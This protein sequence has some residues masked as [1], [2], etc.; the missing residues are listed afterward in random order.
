[1]KYITNANAI[2]LILSDNTK[3]RVEKTDK[4]YPKVLKTF[5]LPQ[6]EQDDAI[7]ALLNPVLLGKKAVTSAEG[8][9]VIDDQIF[10][11]GERLPA[12][13]EQKVLSIMQDGLPLDHFAKFWERLQNNPS[14]T[15]I[16]EL[17]DF[18][19]Y[20][21]LPITEDGFFIA[22]KGVDSDYWSVK[23]N[24]STK[25]TQGTV[26]GIGRILN[27]IGAIIEVP[28]RQVDDNRANECSHGLHVGSLDYVVNGYD[29]NISVP[30]Y[31]VH[32]SV[33]MGGVV[34]PY[35]TA[36]KV[37]RSPSKRIVI[38]V[39][40]GKLTI[41]I[42]RESIE[43]LPSNEKVFLEIEDILT[44]I[45]DDEIAGLTPPKFGDVISRNEKVGQN[46]DGE[47]FKY[48]FDKTFPLTYKYH[49]FANIAKDASSGYDGN[50]T[51]IPLPKGQV[52]HPIYVFPKIKSSLCSWHT[53]L[54]VA[55]KE[56]QKADR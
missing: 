55:L 33:R 56:L 18:L 4:N 35:K 45:S 28:R 13:L 54:Q 26:D 36:T 53:R 24:T 8:F 43:N 25:V 46:Y 10:Y 41:P 48:S 5:E 6:D 23:G 19:S 3:V 42:T 15:S 20:K 7:K 30:H 29:A 39:P 51:T 40:I 34:Y 32:Y 9:E 44:K 38:D 11:Q 49:R 2:I 50:Y 21:E 1:M 17:V 52:K 27:S 47:W 12:A 16:N 22:Y 31:G 14:A 37:S